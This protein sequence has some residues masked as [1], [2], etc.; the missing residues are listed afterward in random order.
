MITFNSYVRQK[1]Y[2]LNTKVKCIVNQ[3]HFYLQI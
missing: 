1:K 3:K 2:K